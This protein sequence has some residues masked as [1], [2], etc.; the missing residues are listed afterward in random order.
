MKLPVIAG[1]ELVKILTKIGFEVDHITGSHM[2]LRRIIYPYIRITV[3]NH[4]E[5]AKGTLSSIL[6]QAG[7]TREAFFKLLKK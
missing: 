7:L 6:R 2:I 3:P 4:P 1:L 5:I